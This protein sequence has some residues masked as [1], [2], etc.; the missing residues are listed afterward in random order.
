MR[1][2]GIEVATISYDSPEV[3]ADFAQEQ[4]ITYKMLSDVGSETITDFGILNT[5]AEEA[6]GP[7][8]NDPDV[9]ADFELL[10]ASGP[11]P[12]ELFVGIAYP[13]TFMLDRDGVV[14]SR[15]FEDSYH[16][17]NST[18]NL[19]LK[20]GTGGST[21]EG[22][23]ISTDHVGILTYPSDA[24][25]APG[26][27]FS[28]ALDIVPLPSMHLYAP[29]A[30]LQNYRV[31]DLRIDPQPF[32][33]VVPLEYPESEIYYFEPLDERVPV[34]RRPLT[35]LQEVLPLSTP[36]AQAAFAEMDELTLTGALDYQACDDELC[37]NPV[38]LPLSWTVEMRPVNRRQSRE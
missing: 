15:F 30:E 9:V 25:V 18:A 36:E 33:R 27:R 3:L 13:G 34:Y 29:G 5:V 24:V 21:V 6:L 17:R 35:L 2:Q 23:E 19:M 4:G 20:L 1:E 10:V 22:T 16:E 28:L 38:S 37:Y 7:N 14:E 26:V 8:A 32:V 11:S 12:S 31:I